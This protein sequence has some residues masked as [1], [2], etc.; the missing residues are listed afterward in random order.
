MN[1]GKF[2]EIPV[3]KP[4]TYR[5]NPGHDT[6]FTILKQLEQNG[7]YQQI[8]N[9][10]V[11]DPSEELTLSEKKVKN[12]IASMNNDSDNQIN[13]YE[14]V[15]KKFLYYRAPTDDPGKVR[16]IFYTLGEQGVSMENAILSLEDAFEKA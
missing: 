13:S 7:H 4:Y 1:F 3:Q 6:S 15:E 5:R 16:I 11:L 12:L 9:Y 10:T 14:E 8:G 2:S